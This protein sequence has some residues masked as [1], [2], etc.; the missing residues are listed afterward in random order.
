MMQDKIPD[1][2]VKTKLDADTEYRSAYMRIRR[3]QPGLKL[4]PK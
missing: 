3:N 2:L 1:Y 4:N